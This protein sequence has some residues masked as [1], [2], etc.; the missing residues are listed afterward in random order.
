MSSF[1][2]LLRTSHGLEDE[3]FTA[4]GDTMDAARAVAAYKLG[5]PE[6]LV[7]LAGAS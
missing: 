4:R 5:V 2:V 6:D 3:G 7:V 1:G